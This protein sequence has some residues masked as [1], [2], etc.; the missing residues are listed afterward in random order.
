MKTIVKEKVK[1]YL[2][3]QLLKTFTEKELNDFEQM[4]LCS[5]FN[6]DVRIVRLFKVLRNIIL[7]APLFTTKLQLLLYTQV[8]GDEILSGQLTYN[9][10]LSLN[11]KMNILTHLAKQYLITEA[12]KD[13]ATYQTDLLN[14]E[15]L[16]RKQYHLFKR[17]H[18]KTAKKFE[19]IIKNKSYYE[20]KKKVNQKQFDYLQQSGLLSKTNNLEELHY[21]IDVHY[22]TEKLSYYITQLTL[23][24]K[25]GKSVNDSLLKT[26]EQ[27]MQLPVYANHPLLSVEWATIRLIQ[28]QSKKAY[29]KVLQMINKYET[30]IAKEDLNGIYVVVANF[31]IQAVRKGQFTFQDLFELY[32]TMD[33][34]DC[35]I[36]DN[37][38]QAASLRSYVSVACR[39]KAFIKA[40]QL[41]E[42]YRQFIRKPIRDSVYYFNLGVI[43]F[44]E[45]KFDLALHHFIRV[46]INFNIQ[47][48]IMMLKSHY[49]LDKEY[50]KFTALQNVFLMNT[51]A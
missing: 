33:E 48:R 16:M 3:V 1:K 23:S 39:A 11:A 43:A 51:K 36:E 42:K 5:Y 49:E 8:F 22:L 17:L 38:I 35:L 2:G 24:D 7:T 19:K 18:N 45:K 40:R 4:I 20:H 25:Y 46:D 12:L 34:K 21:Y 27:L 32:T 14:E 26:T 41:V 29:K 10:Q 44:Y 13:N 31:L 6:K 28:T 47:C 37:Y 15:L 50:C 9:Q 30:S